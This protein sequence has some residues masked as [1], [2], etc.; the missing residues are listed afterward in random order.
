MR[1]ARDEQ[2]DTPRALGDEVGRLSLLA[3]LGE[4]VDAAE[5]AD[6]LLARC[7]D[8][9]ATTAADAR[10]ALRLRVSFAE[11]QRWID[12]LD[13]AGREAEV[14]D[15]AARLLAFYLHLLTHAFDRRIAAAGHDRRAIRRRG[16]LTGAPCARLDA[17]RE[18]VSSWVR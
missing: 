6:V 16:P 2:A 4:A 9:D 3:L 12:E 11:L 13:L 18:R 17:L 5:K 14:R 8:I 15:E 1:G 7:D 10:L